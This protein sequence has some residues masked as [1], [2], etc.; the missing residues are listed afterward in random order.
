MTTLGLTGLGLGRGGPLHGAV[1][2]DPAVAILAGMDR[3]WNADD[4]ADGTPGTWTDRNNSVAGSFA[5]SYSVTSGVVSMTGGVFDTATTLPLTD[6]DAITVLAIMNIPAI[7]S[8]F[9][10]TFSNKDGAN[11]NAD[12]GIRVSHGSSTYVCNVGDGSVATS[13]SGKAV[14]AGVWTL[15]AMRVDQVNGFVN[16]ATS[17]GATLAETQAV[18]S[19][20]VGDATSANN[21]QICGTPVATGAA[22]RTTADVKAVGVSFSAMSD[23]DLVAVANFLLAGL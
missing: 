16:L 1:P 19:A 5:D 12:N 21:L 15:L 4:L 22:T 3:Y 7:G 8:G 13:V 2:L 10:S 14:V 6:A 17:D 11:A 23:S 18:L 9:P 20:S